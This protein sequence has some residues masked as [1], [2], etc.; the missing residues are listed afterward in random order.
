MPWAQKICAASTGMSS[1]TT[2][3]TWKKDQSTGKHTY[4]RYFKIMNC[5]WV[6]LNREIWYMLH[7][8]SSF[9]QQ[10]WRSNT[11]FAN[12][13]GVKNHHWTEE[14]WRPY[15]WLKWTRK[16]FEWHLRLLSRRDY[17]LFCVHIFETWGQNV[18][19]KQVLFTWQWK[20]IHA[21][22]KLSFR[23]RQSS[24]KWLCSAFGYLSTCLERLSLAGREKQRK[25][26]ESVRHHWE[27]PLNPT[28]PDF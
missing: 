17:Y 22:L 7:L 1:W 6:S 28:F 2:P 3:A 20:K 8:A 4:F 10:V 26:L 21:F 14:M 18:V 23:S 25:K 12:L 24:C 19:S 13:W 27:S 16:V 9:L 11:L 15:N 5:Y